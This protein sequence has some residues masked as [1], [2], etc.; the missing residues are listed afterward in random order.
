MTELE[1]HIKDQFSIDWLGYHA[2]Y[3][4]D[5]VAAVD[6]D[7]G[8]SYTYRQLDDRLRRLANG[9]QH[10]FGVGKGDRVA[11]L[12][13]NS[14]AVYECLF[15]G[16]ELGAALMPLNW[17]LSAPEIAALIEHG[18][19][20]V[21]IYDEEFEHLV[22]GLSVPTLRRSPE[23]DT[24]S[25]EQLIAD[26]TP[27]VESAALT[28]DDLSTLLYTSGTTGKPKGVMGTF[29]MMR[30][31]IIHA[32]LHGALN[33][34]SRS[35][36]AAPMFHSAGLYGF[37]MPIFHYGGT[38]YIM[39]NWD[40]ARYLE[41]M[42]DPDIGITHTIGVPIQYA[43]LAQQPA[44]AEASFPT[45]QMAGVGAAPAPGD[46]LEKWAAKGV[47][48]AQS[49]GLTEAFSVCFLLPQ[50][51]RSKP[52]SV[53]H[54]MMHT[55]LKVAD[56]QGNLVEPGV[57]GEIQIKGPAVTPGYWKDPEATHEA[58]LDGW[59]RTGDAARID[60]DGTI[61]I[62]DRYKDMYISGG[63][64]VYPAEIENVLE[65]IPEIL[66]AAVVGVPDERWGE[67]GLAA[68]Q[69]RPG[70][71]LSAE[72]VTEY[73]RERLAGYKVPR[74]VRFMEALPMSAQGKVQK[75]EIKRWFA[76]QEA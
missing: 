54:R 70:S 40:P 62:V 35:L 27:E 7:Q 38:L 49:Y 64:N 59:F 33:A 51:A 23:S 32:A 1:L 47:Y 31:T 42:T 19:P 2:R 29:R 22:E 75:P 36:T 56:E 72:Q 44:F 21:L 41:L 43:M 46:L 3:D 28:I 53:G 34:T 5:V 69:I 68:L 39:K 57:V 45:L 17:R 73:L 66:A 26:H 61:Y 50:S 12:A 25:Y 8:R 9:L 10:A 58:Y 37:S 15:G 14:T 74:H 63:E 52:G 65:G 24:C 16:W 6:V 30:D 20:R 48:L 67:T 71:S 4:G 55:R 18:E 13:Q 76:E 60:H 11:L